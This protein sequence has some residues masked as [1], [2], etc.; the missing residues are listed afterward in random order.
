M[1]PRAVSVI[2]DKGAA[3]ARTQQDGSISAVAGLV[4]DHNLAVGDIDVD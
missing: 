3:I 2:A 4:D 1:T